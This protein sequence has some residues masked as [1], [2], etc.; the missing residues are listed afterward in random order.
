[1]VSTT[2]AMAKSMRACAFLMSETPAG[3]VLVFAVV[4]ASIS[5]RQMAPRPGAMW[6]QARPLAPNSAGISSTTIAMVKWTRQ[7]VYRRRVHR[8]WVSV[9]A[10]VS[11]YAMTMI[12][13]PS[14]ALPLSCNRRVMTLTAMVSMTTATALWT[15]RMSSQPANVALVHAQPSERPCV[16]MVGQRC[17]VQHADQAS[18]TL[19]A[20]ASMKIAMDK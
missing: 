18:R 4:T 12:Q 2:I 16:S 14:I 3:S 9:S 5:A 15:S 6:I 7:R 13:P 17:S 1:M 11:C 8:V 19:P 20:M 10:L